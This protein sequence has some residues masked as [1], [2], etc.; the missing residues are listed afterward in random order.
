MKK[1]IFFVLS[2]AFAFSSQAQDKILTLENVLN[3][4]KEQSPA[5]QIAKHSFRASYWQYRFY[6]AEQLPT[7][8]FDGVIPN[9]QNR[10]SQE[11]T[12]GVSYYA[13]QNSILYRGGLSLNQAIPWTGGNVFVS[14][15]LEH[16]INYLTDTTTRQY[17]STPI[18]IGL[19]QPLFQFNQYKWD[20]KIEP[21]KYEVAKKKYLEA[22]EGVSIDAITYFFRLLTAQ[23]DYKIAEINV[24]NYD[25]LYKVAKG[26][27]N[28]GRIGEDEVLQ[29]E[30]SLLKSQAAMEKNAMDLEDA[31]FRLKSFLRMKDD[32]RLNLVIP[33]PS[34]FEKVDREMALEKALKNSST[35]LE[36]ERRLLEAQ[37]GV[38]AAK[39]YGFNANL[40]LIFGINGSST[41]FDQVY[42]DPLQQQQ[43]SLG[44][45]IP[46]LD[47]GRRKGQVRIAQSNEELAK[48][49]VEQ[50]RVDFSQSI[51]LE[52]GE[53]NIQQNQLIIAAKSDTI[54][55][56]SFVVSKNRYL[57]GKIGVTDLNI[58][59]KETD[60][61]KVGYIGALRT[62]WYNYFRLRRSTLFD[63]QSGIDLDVSYEDIYED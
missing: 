19:N 34:F 53:F 39:A 21:I 24:M 12:A 55:Q 10:I 45:H 2:F 46:I 38:S 52:V 33:S 40:S 48:T 59:Q 16:T 20:R 56:K 29:M 31:M 13:K 54:A 6:K 8:D 9:I 47:W 35:I 41:V 42:Q 5:A 63:F 61:A 23:V 28:L 4:A 3:I 26:R 27:Y 7:L 17:L 43:L 1:Y 37:S 50:E 15:G 11:T 58:A 25:T 57:I 36:F 14:S 32:S 30:L 18:N 51:F 62:Y 60:Q 22:V 49:S 44:L